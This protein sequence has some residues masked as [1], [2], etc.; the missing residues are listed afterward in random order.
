MKALSKLGK[1]FLNGGWN[2]AKA[3]IGTI[4]IK[5]ENVEKVADKFEGIADKSVSILTDDNADDKGQF[6]ALYEEQKYEFLDLGLDIAEDEFAVV[7]NPTTKVLGLAAIKIIRDIVA[8]P[9]YVAT[10]AD[11]VE[12]LQVTNREIEDAKS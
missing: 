11:V 2:L 4:E 9:N 5:N 7:A 3:A 1:I 10:E 8:N 12:L 6:K